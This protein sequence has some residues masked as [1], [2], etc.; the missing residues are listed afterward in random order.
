MA[1]TVPRV[2]AEGVRDVRLHRRKMRRAVLV[3]VSLLSLVSCGSDGDADEIGSSPTTVDE[4]GS[5]RSD[6]ELPTQACIDAFE[7]VVA[8]DDAARSPEDLDPAIGACESLADWEAAAEARP[9]ALEGADP[10]SFART[11]CEEAEGLADTPV[12]EELSG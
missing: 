9:G 8:S 1:S 6:D 12:C 5:L 4:G 7:T 2:V 3:F 11:R 10:E